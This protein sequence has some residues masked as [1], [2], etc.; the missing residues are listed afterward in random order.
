VTGEKSRLRAHEIRSQSDAI[1]VGIGTVLADDPS[2]TVRLPGYIRKDGWPLRVLL[3]S[4]LRLPLKARILDPGPRTVIFTSP[5]ASK[6]RQRALEKKKAVVFRV[7]E[8]KKMLSLRAVLKHLHELGVRALLVEGGGRVHGSFLRERLA[9]EAQLWIAPKVFGE[10]PAWVR[11]VAYLNP[12]QTP[13]LIDTRM[14][15]VGMDYLLT[16]RWEE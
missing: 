8:A 7:P 6:T 4:Q 11:G 3:D 1:L 5:K 9:D 10:G 13:R 16:G 15:A 14:E 12:Q 2:L